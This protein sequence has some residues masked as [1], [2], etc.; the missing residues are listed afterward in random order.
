MPNPTNTIIDKEFIKQTVGQDLVFKKELYELFI[1]NSA[2][3]MEKLRKSLEEKDSSSWHIY[4]HALKGSTASIGAFTLSKIFNEAQTIAIHSK[5]RSAWIVFDKLQA[6]HE[7]LI[8]YLKEQ[9]KLLES[10]ISSNDSS[11]ITKND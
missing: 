6:E 2:I 4:S 9:L 11:T 8:N 10:Q 7:R 5:D 1:N 3:S